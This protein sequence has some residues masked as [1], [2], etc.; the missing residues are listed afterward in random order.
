VATTISITP[1]PPRVPPCK[2]WWLCLT[3]RR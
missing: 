2:A 1:Y 3:S